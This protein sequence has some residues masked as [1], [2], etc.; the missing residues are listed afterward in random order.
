M[1]SDRE[2][3]N[4][5]SPTKRGRSASKEPLE[6]TNIGSPSRFAIRDTEGGEQGETSKEEE[7][8]REEG[9][10]LE[11]K[12]TENR[13]DPVSQ[14]QMKDVGDTNQRISTRQTRGMNKNASKSL[15][16]NAGNMS[17]AVG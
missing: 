8:E 2:E 1:I 9:E 15:A 5:S 6:I 7:G 4:W 10:I 14:A 12:A 16:H 17:S 3:Q 13:I 11:K